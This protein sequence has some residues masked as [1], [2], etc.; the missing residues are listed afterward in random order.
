MKK[1][2]LDNRL[3]QNIKANIAKLKDLLAKVNDEWWYED[4][5]YRFYHHSFKVYQVQE[6]TKEIVDA[7][8]SLAPN[9]PAELN[10]SFL[11]ILEE[12]ASGKKWK[13][14]HNEQ[15]LPQTRP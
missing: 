13:P 2:E 1:H 3:L 10:P 5:I 15:W 9:Q 11:K 6:M 12:G 4:M 8:K 7:L 14:E